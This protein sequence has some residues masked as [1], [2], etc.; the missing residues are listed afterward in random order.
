MVGEMDLRL[1]RRLLGVALVLLFVAG[2]TVSRP[3]SGESVLARPHRCPVPTAKQGLP[4]VEAVA[5]AAWRAAPKML[6]IPTQGGKADVSPRTADITTISWLGNVGWPGIAPLR[7]AALAKC[8][9]SVVDKSW[10]VTF[11]IATAHALHLGQ[12]TIVLVP[13]ATGW[14]GYATR[15]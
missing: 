11:Q 14:A 9:A 4:R 1:T 7:R 10:A 3:S 12:A 8:P 5:R 6:V 2:L 15:L 13:T